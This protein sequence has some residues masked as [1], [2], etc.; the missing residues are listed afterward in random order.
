MDNDK[1]ENCLDAEN[2]L[3][4]K[5]IIKP[6]SDAVHFLHKIQRACLQSNKVTSQQVSCENNVA[7]LNSAPIE[8]EVKNNK[9]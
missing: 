7:C 2:Y 9:K 3:K 4:V 8:A 5:L 1:Q 6:S